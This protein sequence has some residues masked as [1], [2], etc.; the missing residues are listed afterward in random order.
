MSIR[1]LI[2]GSRGSDQA[3]SIYRSGEMDPFMSLHRDVNRLFDEV[4]RGFGT[5]SLFGRMSGRNEAWPNIEISET[6]K[7]IRVAAEVPGLEESDI[8]VLLED[9]VLTLRGEKKSETEDTDRQF[10]ERCYGR[11]ERR[12]AIGRE[13]DEDNVSA[14]F[15]NGVLTVTLPKTEKAQA[16]TKRIAIDSK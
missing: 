7:D 16:K 6:E 15:K 13:V 1:D 10:S 4:F 9:G 2:A 8:E 3:P 5:P 12:L 14:A 11:F